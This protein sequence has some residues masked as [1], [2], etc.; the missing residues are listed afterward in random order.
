[1]SAKYYIDKS[2]LS[3]GTFV[4]LCIENGKLYL[5][6]YDLKINDTLECLS[7][8]YY[9]NKVNEEIENGR[10]IECKSPFFIYDNEDL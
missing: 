2:Y 4:C 10:L 6:T 1:M 7:K 3:F 5:I 9:I 8:Q